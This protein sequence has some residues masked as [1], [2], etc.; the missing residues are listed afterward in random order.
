MAVIAE[1][2]SCSETAVRNK[3]IEYGI[4]R[5]TPWTHLVVDVEEDELCWLYKDKDL[6]MKAIA[7][8]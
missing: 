7:E 8:M 4:E 1:Q 5:R 6:T 2:L 3:L